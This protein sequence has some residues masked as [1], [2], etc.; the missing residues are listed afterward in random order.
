M[1]LPAIQTDQ[2]KFAL[3]ELDQGLQLA[4]NLDL[5]INLQGGLEQ[6]QLVLRDLI[7][8]LASYPSAVAVEP[9]HSFPLLMDDLE[10]GLILRLDQPPA[11]VQP[12]APPQLSSSW[13]VEAVVN[14]YAIAKLELWYHPA[15][16]TALQKKKILS[17]LYNYCTQLGTKL[18]LKLNLYAQPDESSE[19]VVFQETQLQAVQELRSSCDLIALQFPNSALAAA[20]L[21]AELDQPW[22]VSLETGTPRENKQQ[23]RAALENGAQGFIIG[24]ALWPELNDCRQEDKTLDLSAIQTYIETSVRDQMIELV[25][26]TT[27]ADR[28]AV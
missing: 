24:S 25:R 17:E 23:L 22:I 5:D 4:T 26:I 10:K 7:T 15:A 11:Q 9:T 18:L 14:N 13:G 8:H 2:G 27:E 21:T 28:K 12:P 20:T 6:F 3:L 19:P 16:K 1:D